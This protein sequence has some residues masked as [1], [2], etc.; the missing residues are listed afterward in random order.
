MALDRHRFFVFLAWIAFR[1]K[2]TDDM[3]YSMS[4]YVFLDFQTITIKQVINSNEVSVGLIGLFII[5]KI[6]N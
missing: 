3:L 4:K 5:T 6:F 2:D 1:V